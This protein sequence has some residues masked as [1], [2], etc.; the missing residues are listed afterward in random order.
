MIAKSKHVMKNY[1][2]H[3]LLFTIFFFSYSYS[4]KF[5]WAGKLGTTDHSYAYSI[6]TDT[7]NNIVI[8]G[9]FRGMIDLDMGPGQTTFDSGVNS[10]SYVAKYDSSGNLIWS[11]FFETTT[12]SSF[13]SINALELDVDLN[14]NV[15]ITGT[16]NDSVDFNPEGSPHILSPI[17]YA[18]IFVVKLNNNGVLQ[19]VNQFGDA[20]GYNNVGEGNSIFVDSLSNIYLTG[21]FDGNFDFD[22]GV[23][24]HILSSNGD[25]DIFVAKLDPNGNLVWAK[26]VGSTQEDNAL[27][28]VVN[29]NGDIFTTGSFKGTVDFDPGQGNSY[30]TAIFF[31]IFVWKL[32]NNGNFIWSCQMSG[33]NN[34]TGI[35]IDLD[36]ASNIYITGNFRGTVDFDPG[37]SVYAL[38]GDYDFDG[39]ICKLDS[40]SNFQW[41]QQIGANGTDRGFDIH[42][43]DSTVLV[44][45][46][47]EELVNFDTPPAYHYLN[48]GSYDDVYI[49]STGLDNELNWVKH[50]TSNTG[51]AYSHGIVGDEYGNVYTVGDYIFTF[52][53]NTGVDTLN[54]TP[55]AYRDPFI[56]KITYCVADTAPSIFASSC[57]EYNSPN[58]NSYTDSG[59]YTEVLENEFGCDSLVKI[60]LSIYEPSY[61]FMFASACSSYVSPSGNHTWTSSGSYFDTLDNMNGCDSIITINLTITNGFT[62]YDTRT[63]CESYTWIDGNTYTSSNN[64]A[65]Y[66]IVGG[67]SNGCDSLITLNLTIVHPVTGI[68]S[69]TEC[70]S[71]TWIDGNTYTSDNNSATYTIAGGASNGCDSIVSLDLT[72]VNSSTGTDTRTECNSYTWIDGNTYTSSNNTATY[73]IIGGASNGCDSLVTLD[74]T[75]NSIS[76]LS[77]SIVETTI[78]SNNNSAT[79]LWLDCNDNYSIIPGA[80]GQSFTTNTNGNYAVELSENGCVDTTNCVTINTV[81]LIENSFGN[82]LVI[83]PNPTSGKFSID[84]GKSY[85]TIQLLIEDQLGKLIDT[86]IINELQVIDYSIDESAGVYFVFIEADNKRAV[87]KI[88]KE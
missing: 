85:E 38:T 41:V 35:A 46:T 5:D 44:T 61:N 55:D 11:K 32:D 59:T 9:F 74:L 73:N 66:T 19:W 51:S 25:M 81:D 78:S 48:S 30:M 36:L 42:V 67:A 52:D 57:V 8:C 53:F 54:I 1:L 31:E 24:T 14:G 83:Y 72:L 12:V 88:V 77:T 63:E 17:G 75:L 64:T 47:F 39:F 6:D 10:A 34:A 65:T 13:I 58:G 27:G 87:I 29:S 80:T 16:F 79:Y 60:N 43:V 33:G 45:G 56:H 40:S 18:D 71:Y 86:K 68:D 2:F 22:P 82:E 50:I 69:R 84:L 37:Q 3:F 23:N 21:T 28:I 15:Y 70:N 7:S 49:L 76:D 26:S 4:Q 20:Q 62:S